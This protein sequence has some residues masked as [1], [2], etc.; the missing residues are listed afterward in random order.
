[1]KTIIPQTII[2]ATALFIS[3]CGSNS[4]NTADSKEPNA[5][6]CWAQSYLKSGKEYNSLTSDEKDL[7]SK[8][9]SLFNHSEEN[10]Q[11]GCEPNSSPIKLNQEYSFF[12]GAD[13]TLSCTECDPIWSIKFID[14]KKAELWSHPSNQAAMKS[15]L[16]EVQYEYIGESK[17]INISSLNSANVSASCLT[18]FK[19]SWVWKDGKFGMRFYSTSYPDCDFH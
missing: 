10:M 13:L 16:T 9:D 5:C 1:M 15:C 2:L 14:N 19:G 18:K 4:E 7:R 3:S 11:L 8:C 12:D 6:N 17:T